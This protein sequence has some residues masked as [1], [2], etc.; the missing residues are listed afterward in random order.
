[1]RLAWDMRIAHRAR[2]MRTAEP[3]ADQPWARGAHGALHTH[4]ARV[5]AQARQR[6]RFFELADVFLSSGLVPAYT[7]AAFAKRFAR[8]SLTAPP[9]GAAQWRRG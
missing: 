4:P 3:R 1:V 8:L 2:D 6:A 7:A 5:V 9:A